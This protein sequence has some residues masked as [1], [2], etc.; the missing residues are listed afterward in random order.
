MLSGHGGN[1]Y[2]MA[3]RLGCAPSELSDMSN[4]INPLGPPPGMMDFLKDNI[5]ATTRLPE[6][7]NKEIIKK[8]AA[9]FA[10]D[11]DCLLTGNGTTQFIYMI[12]RVLE[13]KRALILGPTYADYADACS[14]RDVGPTIFVT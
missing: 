11:P 10:I 6:V 5:E 9:R 3:R 2:E 14:M 12:P 7:D 4:N 13:T 8:F 1:I